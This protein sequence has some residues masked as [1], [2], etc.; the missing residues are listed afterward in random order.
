VTNKLSTLGSVVVA[1]I[2]S[3]STFSPS[4]AAGQAITMGL[5]ASSGLLLE[6]PLKTILIGDPNIVDVFQRSDR[7]VILQPLHPGATNV[8]FLDEKSIVIANVR[9]LVCNTAASPVANG[10]D[11]ACED[12]NATNPPT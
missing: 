4:H 8:V 3:A 5:G 12:L 1:L 11:P 6:R 10:H 9:I 7:S 2:V